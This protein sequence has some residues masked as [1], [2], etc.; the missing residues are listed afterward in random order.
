MLSRYRNP[1]QDD[2]E[3]RRIAYPVRQDNWGTT[4][5]LDS[6]IGVGLVESRDLIDVALP[7]D[8]AG[9]MVI[10]LTG[11]DDGFVVP[12][13]SP[14][15]RNLRAELQFGTGGA[16]VTVTTDWI[17]GQK[18]CLHAGRVRLRA[19]WQIGVSNATRTIN[20]GA[21]AAFGT[22][23]GH[24]PAQLTDFIIP[25]AVLAANTVRVPYLARTATL[26]GTPVNVPFN[27]DF[28][29]PLGIVICNF[30]VAAYPA[31][32]PVVGGARWITVTNGGAVPSQPRIIWGLD[33]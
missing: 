3:V 25:L 7:D 24:Q 12:T 4:A 17:R 30:V 8:N 19:L 10:T 5:Q 13:V 16:S 1:A 32:V 23:T 27:V 20:V 9:P 29:D 2:M 11:P 22:A 26:A 28:L 15:T 31:T 14:D 6:L 33:L 21:F 18:L